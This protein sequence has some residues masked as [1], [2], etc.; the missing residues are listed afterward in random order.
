[1]AYQ[2]GA[3]ARESDLVWVDRDGRE[4]SQL[5]GGV[6]HREV[7]LSPDGNFAAV[8]ILDDASGASDIWI[9]DVNRGLRTRFTFD[10]AMDWFPSWS[11]D[12][13]R[14]AFSSERTGSHDMWINDVGG[15]TSEQPLYQHPDDNVGPESWSP[16]GKWLVFLRVVDGTNQDI[17]AM[18]VDGGE[19][20]PLVAS[21]FREVSPSVSPDG[22]WL[23]FMSDE[24]GQFEVYVTT[25]P[26][27]GRRWQ[28]SSNGG[29]TPRWRGDG[30]EIFLR[31]ADGTLWAAAVDGSGDTF[32]VGEVSELFS[33]VRP[34]GF[35]S[36]YDV[37]NDGQRFLINRAVNANRAEPL[38]VVLN[39]DAELAEDS[40]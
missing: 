25:F 6:L 23:A 33:W 30:R 4:L 26:E 20:V 37:T 31:T 38:A 19:P 32:T 16:D 10:S 7:R 27:P 3:V 29:T 5:G 14:L 1:M 18:E 34:P 21:S 13:R 28:V 40:R 39:W 2:T 15:S 11:P 9:Y 22:R 8:E 12:G 24:S 35:R 17:W 36:P